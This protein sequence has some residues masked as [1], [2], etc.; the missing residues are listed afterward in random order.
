[1]NAGFKRANQA[2]K[3]SVIVPVYN[4]EKYLKK[5]IMSVLR[6]TYDNWELIL[7]DDGSKDGSPAIV[8]FAA[9]KDARIKAVHQENAGPGAARNLGI[10]EATGDYVVF[11]DSDDYIDKD[12]FR[13]LE[14][15]AKN[16]DVV[17]IDVAQVD[18][19]GKLLKE[20][21]MSQY[22]SWSKDRLLRSQMTGKIP[23]GGVRK[24]VSLTLL[25]DNNIEYTLH[26]IG[27]EAL[28]SFR[29]LYAA[30]KIGFLDVKTVYYYVNHKGSQSK[31]KMRDPWGGVVKNLREYIQQM[32][33]Y[34][35]FADTLNA[36][37]ATATVVSLDKISR[38]YKGKER[39]QEAEKRICEFHN[40][41]D[42]DMGIDL[43]SMN[44]KAKAFV[45]FL[46]RGWYYPVFL[47]S[48]LKNLVA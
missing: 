32:E 33:L 28:Y 38:L 9:K 46:M 1:M 31:I 34:E 25:K 6:Q 36:F 35:K 20:E 19:N 2:M 13:L 14:S 43:D 27:E 12:Y 40:L 29:V 48:R 41:Y 22:K 7:V 8:D 21:K 10:S 26:S 5:C 23:W 17:F 3:I 42:K 18:S 4:A 15:K 39:R 37:N 16:N 45:P 44:Y 11:L 47:C 24:A 30:D